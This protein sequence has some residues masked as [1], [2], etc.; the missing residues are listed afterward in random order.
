MAPGDGKKPI[1]TKTTSS[2]DRDCHQFML[3]AWMTST[4]IYSP[5]WKSSESRRDPVVP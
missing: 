2:I 3:E 1:R 4:K 5:E